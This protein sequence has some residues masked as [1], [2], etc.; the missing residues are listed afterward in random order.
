MRW[1]N[2]ICFPGSL[3]WL[4]GSDVSYNNWVNMPD[5]QAACG[6]I[7]RH[8]GFQWEATGNCSQE[9]NFIC[10]FGMHSWIN[11][12][13]ALNL[14][15]SCSSTII[16]DFLFSDSGKAIACDGQNATLHC[17]S[18]Q[19][20]EIEDSFYGRKTIHYCQSKH[21]ALPASSQEECSWIDVMDSVT[22]I[23]NYFKVFFHQRD[24]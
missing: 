3:A 12:R 21:T 16:F 8:S 2:L 20:I 23:M 18:G 7:L 1:C 6:H 9:L 4:D 13:I 22:G 15:C 5:A 17:G 10:Q 19:V 11:Q 24:V 14:C